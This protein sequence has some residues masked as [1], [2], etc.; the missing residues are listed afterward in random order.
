MKE[1]E[2]LSALEGLGWRCDKD[3]AGDYFCLMD[4]GEVQVQ[5]IPTIGKRSDHFRV[6]LMPS[7]STKNFTAAVAFVLGEASNYVPIIVSNDVPEK[8]VDFS[9]DDVVRL[10]QSAISWASAQDIEKGL[11]AYRAL[12]T[13]SKGAMPLRHLAALAIAGD[14]SCLAN[15]QFSFEQGDRL[16]FV[17]YITQDMIERALLIARNVR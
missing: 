16:G 1:I 8:I 9:L 14:V 11:A 2:I 17:P 6:S 5:I 15:Y 12:P 10:S 3:E 7:V 13:N 4:I